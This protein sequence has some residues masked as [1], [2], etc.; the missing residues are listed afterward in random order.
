[1]GEG[2]P[3]RGAERKA[4][5][6]SGHRSIEQLAA[7][8]GHYC[9]AEHRLFAVTGGWATAPAV[10]AED[11][12]EAECRVWFAAASRRH[13]ALAARWAEHLPVR[14]G[15]DR[16]ALVAPP[17]GPLPG[18]L[19]EILWAAEH[20]PSRGLAG[21]VEGVLPGLAATYG[22]HLEGASPVSE[23]PVMERLVEARREVLGEIRGGEALLQGLT[24]ATRGYEQ[25]AFPAGDE[26]AGAV[27][28][29]FDGFGVFPAVHP[30]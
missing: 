30:S 29:A 26:F 18:L 23:A 17:A 27:E 1:V 20:D 14:A 9:W 15:V 2:G 13:G 12:G 11:P 25:S 19:E 8:V 10:L 24:P 7:L 16:D 4:E 6:G 5:R 22:A 21:L 3:G 28:R